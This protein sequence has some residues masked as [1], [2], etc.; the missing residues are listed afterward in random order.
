MI[1]MEYDAFTHRS[2]PP[3]EPK[4]RREYTPLHVRS[5]HYSALLSNNLYI[6]GGRLNSARPSGEDCIQDVDV[7]DCELL[8]WSKLPAK[9]SPPPRLI[10][11]CSAN[12]GRRF[13]YGYGGYSFADQCTHNWVYQLDVDTGKC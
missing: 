4:G 5:S 7:L 1:N 13:A 3:D 2:R 8:T 10:Y 9:G 6:W 11:G 12:D